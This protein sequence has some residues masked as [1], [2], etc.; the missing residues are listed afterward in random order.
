MNVSYKLYTRNKEKARKTYTKE[1]LMEMSIYELKNLCV[2]HKIIKIYQKFL[3]KRKTC[4]H[5]P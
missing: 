5:Y 4:R 3:W 1:D 2:K